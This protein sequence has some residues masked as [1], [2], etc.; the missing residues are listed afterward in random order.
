MADTDIQHPGHFIKSS[1]I[2]AGMSVK[3]AAELIGVGRPALSNLL[4]GNASLSPDMA[5][6]LEKAFG[7]MRED[8][9]RR[10]AA[11]DDLQNR[12]RE[13]EVAVRAYAPSFLGITATQIEAWADKIDSRAQLPALIRKL[14][15][16][17][18]TGL[19]KVDFPAFDNAQR[20]GWDGQVETDTTTP[21][22]PSGASGWEFGCN[23]EPKPKAEGDYVARVAS[24][25]EAE[26]KNL[27]FVF[28]T[29][30]NWSGKDAWAKE[31]AEEKNWK[32]VKVFD[33]NDLEQWLEQSVPAQNWISEKLGNASSDILSLDECWDRW[34]KVTTPELSRSLFDGVVQTSK[35]SLA[36]WLKNAPDRPYIVTSDSEE[37]SLA[38]LACVLETTGANPEEHKDRALVVRTVEA[39]RRASKASS[40]FIA[41][42]VSPDVE[43]A[44]AG[45]HKTQHTIIVRRKTA[46][47]GEPDIALDLVDDETFRKGLAQTGIPEEDIPALT[48]A[49]GQSLTILRR[50]LSDV[51]AIKFPPWAADNAL[52][53][54]LIPLGLAGA[55][56]SQ[57]KEDQQ[58]LSCL[59]EE[60]YTSTEKAVTDLSQLEHSPVWAVG[61]YRGVASKID[62]LYATHRLV[63]WSDLEKFFFTARIVLSER[64]PALDL[65]EDKRHWA[66]WYGKTRDHSAALREG[67][68]ETLVLLA[69]HGNNLF[70]DRLGVDI[71]AHVNVII[72]EL[73]T[74]FNAETWSSQRS[75]L[76]RYAEAAPDLFLDIVE[77]DLKSDDPKILSLLSP[78]STEIFGGGCPRTG[79]LWALELLA[80]NPDRLPRVA[81]LLARLSEIKIDDNW[82]NKPENS[83]ESIFRAWMPQ[84]A[85]NVQQRCA[86]LETLTRRYPE[87]GWRICIDQFDL[88][89][90]VGHY[91]YRPR[92]RKDASGAGQPVAGGEMHTFQLKAVEL[93]IDWPAHNFRTLGDLVQRL[94]GL[95]IEFHKRVWEAIRTWAASNPPDDEKSG[96]RERIR[97]SAFTRR[98]RKRGVAAKTKDQARELYDL[99]TPGDPV[100][101]HQW[102]FARQWVE[103]SSE[104]IEKEDFDYQ[105][106]EERIKKL[107]ADAVADV[108]NT[109]GYD[110]ILRLCDSGEAS[111]IIGSL[112]AT[113]PPAKFNAEDFLSRLLTE[114]EPLFSS[115]FSACVSGYLFTIDDEAREQLTTSFVGRQHNQGSAGDASILR[116]LK[117]SPFKRQAWRIVD[118]LSEHIQSEYWVKAHPNWYSDEG[119]ELRELVDRMLKA[120][121]PRPAFS[122]VRLYIERMDSH[123]IVRLLKEIATSS[124]TLDENYRFHSYDIGKAFKVLDDHG[125]VS[126]DELAHL[127]FLYLSALEHEKRGIPNLERQ[128]VE[129]PAMFV[130]AIGLLYKRSDD[131][132]DPVEWQIPDDKQRE[133]VAT[134]AY[135]LLHKAKLIPGTQDDGTIKA[136]KLKAWISD[137][138]ALC[139]TYARETVGDSVIGELLSKSGPG[140]DGIWPAE[141]LRDALEDVGTQKIA[142]GMAIGLYNQRGAH[143]RDVGGKQ[144]RELA[145]KYISWSRQVAVEHPFTSRLLERISQSYGRD[146]EWQDTDANLRKRLPY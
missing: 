146:A 105:K 26:R 31:K 39:L 77:Q 37:E 28:V 8:L 51:P 120:N 49:S 132:Q 52:T 134:Q 95:G 40:S 101:R 65:P 59:T 25:P 66:G 118:G 121:R 15:L 7:V 57:S 24:V 108:W 99:L 20:H 102:L 87:I 30:R 126:R 97:I 90:A 109:S 141:G 129:S 18:G 78:S 46:V 6:R 53:R 137:V 98:G 116:L 131:G 50:R 27:S 113:F 88:G 43:A 130:Q 144:E 3:K 32:D 128:L 11:F 85:S 76:P 92:W 35:S 123:T 81:S 127:E 136:S 73:L 135:H 122:A 12:H 112:L 71:E 107:R 56:N 104:E 42:I 21:W 1:V 10:Q 96:L 117:A 58:V 94:H 89:S 22:I 106:R 61:R 140:K 139:K 70:R 5:L 138:R 4:N 69:I 54:K 84:T 100:G 111:S 83:L 133:T 64:D 67:I 79:L 60:D 13:K 86:V 9:L 142:D 2:P 72:R 19:S 110:G 23:K 48:R 125:D 93:A 103:E 82:S 33:A 44:S 62:V 55:W 45:L 63:T 29:P 36:S 17:T 47:E 124:S 16:S 74:P 14:V 145:A 80:W 38:F 91:S 143:W 68:C 34:S 41:V 75:D 115:H 119:E 114:P